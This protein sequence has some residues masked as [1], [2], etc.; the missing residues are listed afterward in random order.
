MRPV[1]PPLLLALFGTLLRGVWKL[2]S[3][4][5]FK[6]SAWCLGSPVLIC[7]VYIRGSLLKHCMRVCFFWLSTCSFSFSFSI[8][9]FLHETGALLELRVEVQVERP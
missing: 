6:H 9:L 2:H 5:G 4:T 8:Q 1:E 3:N 7:D